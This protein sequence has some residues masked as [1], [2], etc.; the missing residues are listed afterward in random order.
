[1]LSGLANV[2]MIEFHCHDTSMNIFLDTRRQIVLYVPNSSTDY[3]ED[4]LDFDRPSASEA[5]S[6]DI[7]HRLLW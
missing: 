1:M 4:S 3:A 7:T 2:V 5:N 6:Y